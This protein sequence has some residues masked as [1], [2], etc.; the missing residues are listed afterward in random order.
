MRKFICVAFCLMFVAC[1]LTDQ[2]T[3]TVKDISKEHLTSIASNDL[4]VENVSSFVNQ[5]PIEWKEDPIYINGHT[6]VIDAK[7]DAISDERFIYLIYESSFTEDYVSRIKRIFAKNDSD[8]STKYDLQVNYAKRRLEL[9]WAPKEYLF[10]YE[11]WIIDDGGFCDPITGERERPHHLEN[12]DISEEEAIQKAEVLLLSFGIDSSEYRIAHKEKGRIIEVHTHETIAEGW[13]ITY[14]PSVSGC[15]AI[16]FN[17]L[18]RSYPTPDYVFHYD[19][20]NP[21][22]KIEVFVTKDG[23][24]RFFYE[25]PDKIEQ[26]KSVE[27]QLLDFQLVTNSF[28]NYFITAMTVSTVSDVRYDP[29]IQELVLS[30]SVRLVEEPDKYGTT[31]MIRPVWVVLYTNKMSSSLLSN[32]ISYVC[33]DAI[34]GEIVEPV[35]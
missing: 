8:I 10:Q 18:F 29:I 21:P 32:P 19:P 34:T 6:I 16:Y 12:V 11:S 35:R 14:M 22:P 25:S 23:C 7:V 24:V 2:N 9:A 28:K 33:I 15:Y 26:W 27:N 17:S 13:N 5:W 4:Q 3:P 20:V 31:S 30:Y 1:R